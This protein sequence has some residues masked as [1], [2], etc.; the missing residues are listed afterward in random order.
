MLISRY[1]ID[2]IPEDC[3]EIPNIKEKIYNIINLFN[4]P[5]IIN[6]FSDNNKIATITNDFDINKNSDFHLEA[7]DFLQ[8]LKN[9][10]CDIFLFDPPSNPN[11]MKFYFEEMN[12]K[13]HK[14]YYLTDYWT[15]LK[16]EITRILKINGYVISLGYNS[17]G[18]GKTNGFNIEEILILSNYY[19]KNDI[20]C[21]IDKK[22]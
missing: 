15:K 18:V 11:R 17:G 20:F 7:L 4:N 5:T 6:P 21:V 1:D 19:L 10:S 2:N 16:K 12:L 3:F 13:L 8:H 14:K 22:I 9:D